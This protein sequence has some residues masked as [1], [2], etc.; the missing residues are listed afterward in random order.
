MRVVT[1]TEMKKID[2]TASEKH[3][4]ASS[5]LM[6]NAGKEVAQRASSVLKSLGSGNVLVVAGAGNNGGDGFVAARHLSEAGHP[7]QV[8]VMAAEKEFKGDTADNLKQ[9][10]AIIKPVFR[11]DEKTIK[12]ATDNA[13][14]II[15]ALFGTGFKGEA[16]VL[17][18]QAICA[19]NCANVFVLSVDIP[20]GVEAD[21][22]QT[23]GAVVEADET[24]TFGL[25]KLGCVVY[26]GAAY[27]GELT[28][29]DIGFPEVLIAT[30]GHIDMPAPEDMARLLPLR[31][32]DAFKQSAGR[33][34]VVA[35]SVG[36]T[37]AAAMCAAAALRAGAGIVTLAVPESLNDIL[38]TK[39]TEV[40][41]ASLPE[42]KART[43]SAEAASSILAMLPSFDLLILGPGLSQNAETL[44]TV[45]RV[46][47]ESS[48]PLVL[49]ADGLNA[50]E[51]LP[52]V[53]NRRGGEVIVTPHPGELS[54]LVGEDVKTIQKDRFA[55]AREA[56]RRTRASVV[57]KGA[58]TV[59]ASPDRKLSLNPTGNPGMASAGTGDVLAGLIGGLWVQHIPAFNAAVLGTYLHGLA[60]DLAADDLTGFCLVAADL[61][62][63]MP[64]AF[65]TIIEA[66]VRPTIQSE[67]A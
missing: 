32:P 2:K 48:L 38:E 20:S 13:D 33:V 14:L 8:L 63:Y 16:P 67:E 51:G 19:I 1:G 12:T 61:I 18:A 52:E 56:A 24:V 37:G 54:R 53:L 44:E 66:G 57:L 47:A 62:E 41:T 60:G 40:M 11:P 6:E 15:D 21:T 35:G 31:S 5:T 17:V 64:E 65:G 55:A 58:R 42:T 25:P 50:L 29:V 46:V 59:I 10:K 28:I 7:V 49:D 4:V 30:A 36:M 23:G 3:N 27:V 9:L 22:G 34:L 26:P 45:R 43:I 39:L